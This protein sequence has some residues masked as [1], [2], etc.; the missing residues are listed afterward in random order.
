M[1]ELL[2][3]DQAAER[4]DLPKSTLRYWRLNGIGPKSFK[5]GRRVVYAIPD[6]E[7]W[8]QQQREAA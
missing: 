2:T 5:L 6:L 4:L 7:S 1:P 3:L 8:L